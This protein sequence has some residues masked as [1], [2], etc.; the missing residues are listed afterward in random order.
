[1]SFKSNDSKNSRGVQRKES[2]DGQSAKEYSIVSKDYSIGSILGSSFVSIGSNRS[3]SF[4]GSPTKDCNCQFRYKY[5][6]Y[7][8]LH[9]THKNQLDILKKELEVAKDLNEHF[10]N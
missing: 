10:E 7:K 2:L 9:E 5:Y 3:Q 8:S 6:E 1:M 4:Y